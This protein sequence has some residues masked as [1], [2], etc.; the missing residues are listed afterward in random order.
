MR[1]N[2]QEFF[3][4]TQFSMQYYSSTAN[5]KKGQELASISNVWYYLSARGER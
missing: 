5:N 3:K 4:L 1:E 2:E